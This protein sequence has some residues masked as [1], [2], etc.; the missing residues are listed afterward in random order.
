MKRLF[1]F[2][3]N[4]SATDAAILFNFLNGSQDILNWRYPSMPGT[5]FLLSHLNLSGI[6]ALMHAHMT[7]LNYYIVE[8]NLS[9]IQGWGSNDIWSFLIDQPELPPQQPRRGLLS[10]SM[11]DSLTKKLPGS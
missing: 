9:S 3:Y 1:M 11:L 4:P 7:G 2:S 6:T 8:F 10:P 5:V